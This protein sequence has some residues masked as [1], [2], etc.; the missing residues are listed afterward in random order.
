MGHWEQ[1]GINL[2]S[3]VRIFFRSRV[4]TDIVL[5]QTG[6]GKVFLAYQGFGTEESEKTVKKNIFIDFFE[7]FLRDFLIKLKNRPSLG[8]KYVP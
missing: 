5:H 6:W 2:N 4:D 3:M 7:R 8:V 1:D